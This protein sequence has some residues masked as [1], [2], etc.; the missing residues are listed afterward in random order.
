LLQKSLSE[1][2]KAK[3]SS[4]VKKYGF[5]NILKKSESLEEV[6]AAGSKDVTMLLDDVHSAG[7][8]LKNRPFPDE[9]KQYK[10]AV[11]NFM[12]FVLGNAYSVEVK[13]GIAN[14]YKPQ[15]A[16]KK[17]SVRDNKLVFTNIE[18]IDR[19]LENLA[20]EIMSAQIAQ[21]K[22]L[23]RIEEINGL[24]INLLR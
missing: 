14:K 7:D 8:A 1:S 21:I 19:K 3:D 2:K 6:E 10:A 18:V 5:R 4:P 11:R 12:R 17:G 13:E 15:F 22:L 24:L 20:N 23:S 9:I 16:N